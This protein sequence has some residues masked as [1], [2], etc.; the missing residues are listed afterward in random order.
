MP[1]YDDSRTI[2]VPI[3][4]QL[5]CPPPPRQTNVPQQSLRPKH[6]IEKGPLQ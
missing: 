6:C 5:G 2:C 1:K 4:P 3:R